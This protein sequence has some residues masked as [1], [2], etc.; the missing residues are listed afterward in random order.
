M[1]GS[2]PSRLIRKSVALL[3]HLKDTILPSAV[4]QIINNLHTL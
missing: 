1:F 4:F 2:C 3:V